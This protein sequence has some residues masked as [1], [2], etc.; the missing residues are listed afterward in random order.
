MTT[1]LERVKFLAPERPG[2]AG[3]T[4]EPTAVFP[5]LAEGFDRDPEPAPATRKPAKEPRSAASSRT[6]AKQ[7]RTGGKF[8]STA[9]QVRTT[10]DEIDLMLKLLA[11][12]WS[13]GDDEDCPAVLNETS[14]QIAADMAKLVCRSPFLMEHVSMGGLLGDIL[15]FALSCKPLVQQMWHHHGPAA[16]RARL[17]DPEGG[18][19]SVHV[20]AEPS[21]Q[22]D[23]YGPY[24]PGTTLA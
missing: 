20:H 3:T 14:S 24:R 4:D 12:A 15:K 10:A 5:D 17:E 21:V 2:E 23:R 1:L 7:P 19:A 11:G 9:A 6:A 18:Y 8:V 13:L 22:P 16:R